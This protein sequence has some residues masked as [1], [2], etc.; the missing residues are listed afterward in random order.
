MAHGI[1]WN[2]AAGIRLSFSHQLPIGG[3]PKK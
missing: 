3:Y 1:A 2:E